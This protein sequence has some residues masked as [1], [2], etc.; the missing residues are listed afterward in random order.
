MPGSYLYSWGLAAGCHRERPA[1]PG[2]PTPL[3]GESIPNGSLRPR[4]CAKH[5][6]SREGPDPAAIFLSQTMS[7]QSG[8]D[9]PVARGRGGRGDTVDQAQG[10]EGLGEKSSLGLWLSERA[11]APGDLGSNPSPAS[12]WLCDRKLVIVLPWASVSCR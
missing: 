6:V 5:E 8:R 2:E 3:G 1:Q 9:K 12:S 7:Q 4:S 10:R 11:R